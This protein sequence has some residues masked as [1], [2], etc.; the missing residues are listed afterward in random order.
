MSGQEP[1]SDRFIQLGYIA[2]LHGVNGWVKIF[3]FTQPR[4]AILDYQPWLLGEDRKP[5]T[6]SRGSRHG[7]TVIAELPGVD[8]R[9]QARALIEQPIAVDRQ[10]LPGLPEDEYYWADLEG[11]EVSAR[12][13]TVLGRISRMMETGA[14]DVMVV[15]GEREILIPFVVGT[16]VRSVDIDAGRIEV[17]WDPEFLD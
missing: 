4:E 1:R 17:D 9:D 10:Q 11:L 14:N 8:D 5:V 15:T 7:K 12:D 3:S 16:T 2:G 13:G 6:V